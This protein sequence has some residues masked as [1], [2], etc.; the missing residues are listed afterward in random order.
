MKIKDGFMLREIADTWIVVPLRERVI[1][2]NSMITL[3]G[4]AALIWKKLEAGADL[5]EIVACI[6]NEYDID[7][8]TAMDDVNQ[9]VSKIA[10]KGLIELGKGSG[11][12]FET[13]C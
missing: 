5:N 6:T 11:W 10:N 4:S 9:F 12:I 3:N 1:E 8:H 13:S 7:A 2:F